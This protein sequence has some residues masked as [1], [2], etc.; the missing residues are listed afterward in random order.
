MEMK[1]FL[2]YVLLRLAIGIL[3]FAVV[4]GVNGIFFNK[5]QQLLCQNNRTLLLG[6]SHF[7]GL[8]LDGALHQGQDSEA[9]ITMYNKLVDLTSRCEIDKVM[10]SFSYMNLSSNYFDDF[11]RTNDIQSF[12]M[13][14]RNSSFVNPIQ[15]LSDKVHWK[16]VV[17]VFIRY[18]YTLDF[19]LLR[20]V[21]SRDSKETYEKEMLTKARKTIDHKALRKAQKLRKRKLDVRSA[22]YKRKINNS[23]DNLFN[24]KNE[25]FA[26]WNMSYLD[27]IVDHCKQNGIKLWL[28]NT[29]LER[30]YFNLIPEGFRTAF[31]KKKEQYLDSYSDCQYVD[32]TDYFQ[33]S[34]F[35]IDEHHITRYGAMVLSEE[36][37]GLIDKS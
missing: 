23:I 15:L 7:N 11:L 35:F 27:K 25:E 36:L 9:Y 8:E 37:Q 17:K 5:S 24:S 31:E 32:K 21:F 22:Q 6:D 19:E 13:A 28:V 12:S 30:S 3:F 20:K 1:P 18:R 16:S 14:Q 29:P 2:K 34:D 10:V 33:N 26:S 4:A